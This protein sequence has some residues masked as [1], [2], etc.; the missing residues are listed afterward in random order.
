MRFSW[1]ARMAVRAAL[2]EVAMTAAANPI[3]D[4]YAK[5]RASGY[6]RSFVNSLLPDWW[7]DDIASSPSG[8][9]QASLVLGKLLGVRP[10]SLWTE[11]SSVTL[12]T[13]VGRKFKRRAD[14]ATDQL[15]IAC[16]IAFATARLALRGFTREYRPDLL[17]D[18]SQL[19]AKIL[20]T[21]P[22]VALADLLEYCN[23]IG[24]PVI[25]LSHFPAGVKKMAGLAFEVEGRPI[26]VITQ[27]KKH[28]Y[29][30][31]DLAHE[32]GHI[33][34]GHVASNA[35]IVDQKIDQESGDEDERSANRFALE[36]LTGD[37]D[38]TIRPAGRNLTGQELAT[39][40]QRFGVNRKV[41]PMHVVLNYGYA[42]THWGPANIALGVLAGDAISDQRL[43][44]E[45][46]LRNLDA[47][48][49]G[50]D[51]VAALRTY[52]GA[53]AL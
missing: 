42:T 53:N 34:L 6:S 43:A 23:E 16:A 12:S 5:L 1:L 32:L 2:L 20:G 50:E 47:E 11:Q 21:A 28:G 37:P 49:L 25:H 46:L 18:A 24:L 30:L 38:C 3:R 22:W 19:R 35:C 26:V 7:E 29:Y 48:G 40:A 13:P 15:D 14:A 52:C 9:Q 10:E 39:A 41:D 31:F 17:V 27:T 36:L 45:N 4:I 44:Q 33:T 8:L 51:D